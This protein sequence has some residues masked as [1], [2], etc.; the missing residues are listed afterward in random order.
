MML[1][2]K[3]W[4]PVLFIT[5]SLLFLGVLFF[6]TII[7][8]DLFHYKYLLNFTG[9]K[10]LLFFLITATGYL[11]ASFYKSK[12]KARLG[13]TATFLLLSILLLIFK[14]VT[15][16]EG[17]MDDWIGILSLLILSLGYSIG[18]LISRQKGFKAKAVLILVVLFLSAIQTEVLDNFMFQQSNFGNYTG[19]QKQSLNEQQVNL[20]D[21][22]FPE[23]EEQIIFLDFWN[24]N[25]GACFLSFPDVKNF[26]SQNENPSLK[27]Y[28]V[29]VYRDS[30]QIDKAEEI[31]AAYELDS[32]E[33]VH[34]SYNE[35]EQLGIEGY[36]TIYVI[37]QD[38]NI[39]F[40]G[41]IEV[42]N[43]VDP[44]L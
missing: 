22:N 39:R 20:L 13:F 3:T 14:V 17:W 38:K 26:T 23:F 5:V 15:G 7:V 29:N 11:T 31:H 19:I 9:S 37:D 24:I 1:S 41:F 40:E 35:A 34:V 28:S 27:F 21:S 10:Y 30:S 44:W 25:C 2:K 36:P 18:V 4:Q 16:K 42:L 12:T 6:I 33:L 32:L 8:L 43:L